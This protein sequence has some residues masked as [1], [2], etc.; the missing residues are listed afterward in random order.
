MNRETAW[1]HFESGRLKAGYCPHS[2]LLLTVE[3]E[4]ALGS[5]SC[6]ICDCFGFAPEEVRRHK[7]QE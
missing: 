7:E 4:G 1:R 2:G 6:D 5:L 3:G